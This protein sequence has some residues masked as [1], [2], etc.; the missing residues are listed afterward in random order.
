MAGASSAEMR[1]AWFR[2][3]RLGTS[4]P[5][6]SDRY[7]MPSTTRPKLTIPAWGASQAT[8]L[9]FAASLSAMVAPPKAPARTPTSVMPIWI[10]ER[11]WLG[12]LARSRAT[13]APGWPSSAFCCSRARRDATRA[14]SDMASRPFTMIR[15]TMMMISIVSEPITLSNPSRMAMTSRQL[16]NAPEDARGDHNE[17]HRIHALEGGDWGFMG[18]SGPYGS[19][20]KAENG[21]AEE[22]R[23]VEIP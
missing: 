9:N 13:C 14:I 18:Q 8:R 5:M 4:S 12:E 7:V 3:I 23:Q 11:N 10:V 20:K 2:A 17:K 21:E 22:R 1:S 16:K 19:Q 15:A 6:T